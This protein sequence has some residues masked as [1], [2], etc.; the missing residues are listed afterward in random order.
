MTDKPGSLVRVLVA[1]IPMPTNRFLVDLN[2]QLSKS[3]DIIHNSDNF[4]ELRG[5][6]DII[7]LHFPEYLTFQ[8]Q[9]AYINGLDTALIAET[10]KRLQY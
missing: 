2:L 6:Y 8:I 10:E 7:H 3:C 5:D 4:W 1:Q 9:D